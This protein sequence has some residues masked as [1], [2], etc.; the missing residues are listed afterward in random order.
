M[1]LIWKRL[2]KRSLV[3]FGTLIDISTKAKNL[4]LLDFANTS[5]SYI[6][7]LYLLYE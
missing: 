7:Y 3:K 1:K 2:E 6:L 5:R 4:D